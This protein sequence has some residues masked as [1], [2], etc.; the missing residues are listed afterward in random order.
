MPLLLCA[1]LGA[2]VAPAPEKARTSGVTLSGNAGNLSETL[3]LNRRLQALLPADALLLG[4]QHDAPAH[5]HLQ[6]AVVQALAT[7]GAL[8]ALALEMADRGTSTAGLPP[9]ATEAQVQTALRWSDAAWPWAAYG[10]VV[11]AAVRS[12]IPAMGANLPRDQIRNAMT[13]VALDDHLTL[14]LWQKQQEIIREGH[15]GLLPASQIVPMTR[16]QTARDAAMAQ[17]IAGALQPGKT[18]LL[19]A[20]NGHV[21]RALGVPTH[22][23]REVRQ[24]SVTLQPLRPS[25]TEADIPPADAVWLTPAVPPKDHCAELRQQM[26]PGPQALSEVRAGDHAATIRSS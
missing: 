8:A 16:V 18:V 2:C 25:G 9:Q 4:E 23:A 19:I 13:T 26:A 7:N 1:M 14:A 6:A 12:G 17:T 5:Q 20:G 10:P 3:E 15:C 22:L 11:M 21:D 24:K